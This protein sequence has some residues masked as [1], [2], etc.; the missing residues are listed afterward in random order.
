MVLESGNVTTFCQ[1]PV[2]VDNSNFAFIWVV[3]L[4]KEIMEDILGVMMFMMQ[5]IERLKRSM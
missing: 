5:D 3:N 4:E 1:S 2:K